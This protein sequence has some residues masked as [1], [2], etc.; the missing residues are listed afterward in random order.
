MGKGI[1]DLMALEVEQEP[2]AIDALLA[3][4]PEPTPETA[5]EPTPVQP[6]VSAIDALMQIPEEEPA[7]DAQQPSAIAALNAIPDTPSRVPIQFGGGERAQAL[8]QPQAPTPAPDQEQPSVLGETG[9]ALQRG[10]LN[11]VASAGDVGEFGA[12]EP[13]LGLPQ[14][15]LTQTVLEAITPQ[16]FD[17]QVEANRKKSAN[18]ARR[19][20]DMWRKIAA[21]DKF[22]QD[23]ELA[24]STWGER[25]FSKA[26]VT[27]SEGAPSFMAAIAT[28]IVTKSPVLPSLMLGLQQGG[29]TFRAARDKG[30]SQDKAALLGALNT[31]WSTVA[32]FIPLSRMMGRPGQRALTRMAKGAF[33]EGLQELIETVGSNTIAH[34]G[35]DKARGIMD[36]WLESIVGGV[37]L[38]G[39]GGAVLGG[40]GTPSPDVAPTA[41][42]AA[43]PMAAAGERGRTLRERL[44]T[45]A[46]ADRRFDG[47]PFEVTNQEA[48]FGVETERQTF[49]I[50]S[51]G[52][53]G[54]GIFQPTKGAGASA[55]KIIVS[56]NAD[57]ELNGTLRLTLEP[58]GPNK[59]EPILVDIA[60]GE[61]SERQ[62]I[63]RAMVRNATENG[64][65]IRQA[66]RNGGF[67][68]EGAAFFNQLQSEGAL[69]PTQLRA[70]Q[71]ARPQALDARAQERA[72]VA[73]GATPV[74]RT[75]GTRP[76]VPVGRHEQQTIRDAAENE[77]SPINAEGVALR[78]Q[79]R[80]TAANFPRD[81]RVEAGRA[82]A[83]EDVGAALASA[84]SE[85]DSRERVAKYAGLL[86]SDKATPGQR[87]EILKDI[88]DDATMVAQTLNI[89]RVLKA[90]TPEG[91]G[92]LQ[93]TAFEKWLKR[94]KVKVKPSVLEQLR[95]DLIKAEKGET[96]EQIER[97][98]QEAI[99]VAVRSTPRMKFFWSSYRYSNVL[100]GVRSQERNVVGNV[101]Q[102]FL[103]RPLTLIAG[104]HPI[105]AAIYMKNA[106]KAIGAGVEGWRS[107][108][109]G[110]GISKL[111]DIRDQTPFDIAMQKQLPRAIT[112]VPRMMEGGDRFL[113]AMI[114]SGET[115][116][117]LSRGVSQETATRRAQDLR[118]QYLFRSELG[119]DMKD[120]SQNLA[121]RG[122]DAFGKAL[123]SLRRAPVLGPLMQP[124][125]MFI[126]TPINIAKEGTKYSLFGYAGRVNRDSVAKGMFEKPFDKL[127]EQQK[128]TVELQREEIIGMR[129]VGIALT[130]IGALAAITGNTTWAA[131]RDEKERELFYATGRKPYSVK[132]GDRW[133]PLW[134]LGPLGLALAMPAAM[135]DTLIDNPEVSN[136]DAGG[137]MA[138]FAVQMMNFVVAQ[139]PFSSLESFT[140]MMGGDE[141]ALEDMKA[142]VASQVIPASGFLRYV[143]EFV[144]PTFRRA[145]TAVEKIQKGLPVGIPGVIESSKALPPY[146]TPEDAPAVK[147]WSDRLPPFP[148]GKQQ[149]EYEDQ[150]QSRHT[151]IRDRKVNNKTL[152]GIVASFRVGDAQVGDIRSFI[153]NFD[154]EERGRLKSRIK[155]YHGQQDLAKRMG[156]SRRQ[157]GF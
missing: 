57:G 62:G 42:V 59:G 37:G 56:R 29:G 80:N 143:N 5:P 134:T 21:Q 1:D 75:A 98:V 111:I 76:N 13:T 119:R 30:A 46:D 26:S 151:I 41:D 27:I 139:T 118:Q 126:R 55:T 131:P 127:T 52:K 19:W 72:E 152:D 25:P 47:D 70:E 14:F 10:V 109:R 7:P 112:F 155:N 69:A 86:L 116:R 49:G 11:L 125:L 114:E 8:G 154:A 117:L 92:E 113:G 130:A 23:P 87:I 96:P 153:N 146:L 6:Q 67:T 60:V 84:R 64:F 129:R 28:A 77:D 137:K 94:N 63:G 53:S 43:E 122:L 58:R 149:D 105:E 156:G 89:M 32:E 104:G 136:K 12:L 81:E 22:A 82:A 78:E 120:K 138:A 33:E 115:A 17:D 148:I 38:G 95:A 108:M 88:S 35:F 124:V 140:A 39:I 45:L 73:A 51:K 107:A 9:K 65:D 34:F 85:T 24:A 48:G 83:E 66:L 150:L 106:A 40:G 133:V 103:A 16:W 18:V 20:A 61:G 132:V 54:I 36:G 3:F 100:S 102:A 2:S 145:R 91:R 128:E 135:R 90:M 44:D 147:T 4:E 74:P 142:S 144:D 50:P 99:W 157:F 68:P 110:E 121:A 123:E 71:G 79:E 141:K 15:K 93:S 97:A 31:A 101:L